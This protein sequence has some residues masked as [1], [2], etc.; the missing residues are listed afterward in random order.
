MMEAVVVEELDAQ[1]VCDYKI[2]KSGGKHTKVRFIFL[3]QERSYVFSHTPSDR[4]AP[5]NARAGIRRLLRQ[6][7]EGEAPGPSCKRSL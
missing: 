7:R 2:D 3:D 1:G 5:Y 4:R 6:L